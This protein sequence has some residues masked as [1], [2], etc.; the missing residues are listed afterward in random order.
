MDRGTLIRTLVLAIA[1]VNQVLVSVGLYEIPG[2]SEEWTNILTNAFTV[3]SAAVA[4]FKNN[5]VTAKGK[6][7]KEVLKANNLTKAK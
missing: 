4:W 6:M 1:L 7:Q 5:Y 2:T 3:I